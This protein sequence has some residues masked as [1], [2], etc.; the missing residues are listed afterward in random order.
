MAGCKYHRQFRKLPPLLLVKSI[1]EKVHVFRLT[2]KKKKKR[3]KEE[4]ASR[5][6]VAY[7][8]ICTCPVYIGLYICICMRYRKWVVGSTLDRGTVD[9]GGKGIRGVRERKKR[10]CSRRGASVRLGSLNWKFSKR[11]S[12][13]RFRG[14][15]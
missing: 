14:E 10:I 4:R 9:S 13:I 3:E 5:P 12:G 2:K 15:G 11:F 8:C 6:T 7:V 1:G